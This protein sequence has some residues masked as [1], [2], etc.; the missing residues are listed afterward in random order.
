MNAAPELA[1]PID[2]GAR[3]AWHKGLAN[4]ANFA[5]GDIAPEPNTLMSEVEALA[6]QLREA[7]D[8]EIAQLGRQVAMMRK[9][10][11]QHVAAE[12]DVLRRRARRA[13]QGGGDIVRASPWPTLGLVALAAGAIGFIAARR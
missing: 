7:A 9:A 5:P 12:S 1:A 6:G 13:A 11:R 8:S 10:V 3:A 4:G 2:D